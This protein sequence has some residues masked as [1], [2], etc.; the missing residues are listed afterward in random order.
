MIRSIRAFLGRERDALSSDN[1]TPSGLTASQ[2]ANLRDFRDHDGYE[3]FLTRLDTAITLYAER[4]LHSR[5]DAAIHEARGAI[6]GLRNAASLVDET[7]Q[8]H[9][10]YVDAERQ[11][12]S[13]EHGKFDAR[14]LVAFASPGWHRYG[15]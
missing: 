12:A 9:D 2:I 15:Q 11:R 3:V 1:P 14:D 7:I 10:R 6:L 5:D 8:A 13:V 4:L